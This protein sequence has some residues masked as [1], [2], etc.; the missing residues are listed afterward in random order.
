MWNT[1]YFMNALKKLFFSLF[2]IFTLGLNGC[3]MFRR[4]SST[5]SQ[6]GKNPISSDSSAANPFVNP[7]AIDPA[8]PTTDKKKITLV[9][10]GAGISSFATIGLLKRLHE[11]G[12]VIESIVTTGW[13]TLF[14]LAAGFLKSIHD[15][16][17]FAMRLQEKDF[18][19]LSLF[20]PSHDYSG[21]EKIPSI[22]ES[23]FK[24]KEISDTKFPLIISSAN[25]ET[26]EPYTFDRGDWRIPLFKTMAVPGIFRPYPQSKN[27]EP[28]HSLQGINVDEAQKR[29]GGIIVA[30]EMYGDYVDFLKIGKKDSSNGVFRQ[31][32][33][34]SL[35]KGINKELMKA[36]LQGH[37]QLLTSPANF[38]QKRLAIFAGYKEGARLAKAIRSFNNN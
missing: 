31:L 35:K 12:V 24:Q 25:T 2:L 14:V 9:L 36:N 10:G 27:Q 34:A 7:N 15:V 4:S 29:G 30:V 33:L 23:N 32:Y 26:D 18:Y 5:H 22:V 37:I 28:I 16:E 8:K 3:S 13:P 1:Y 6:D 17:W 20:D 21:S 11:E 38:S 19:N